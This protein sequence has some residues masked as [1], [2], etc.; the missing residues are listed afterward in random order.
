MGVV[1]TPVSANPSD[2]S[3]TLSELTNPSAGL[4][5]GEDIKSNITQTNLGKVHYDLYVS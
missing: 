5:K 2:A 3:E 4:H 1:F